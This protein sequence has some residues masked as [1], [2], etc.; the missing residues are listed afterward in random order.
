MLLECMARQKHKYC[1]E[2]GRILFIA[3]CAEI[4]IKKEKKKRK[5]KEATYSLRYNR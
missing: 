1:T 4:H 2:A 5:E 3:A